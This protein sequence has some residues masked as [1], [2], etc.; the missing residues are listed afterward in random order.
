MVGSISQARHSVPC[1]S[2]RM[3]LGRLVLHASAHKI[4]TFLPLFKLSSSCLSLLVQGLQACSTSQGASVALPKHLSLVVGVTLA[5]C[6]KTGTNFFLCHHFMR[7]FVLTKNPD[8]LWQFLF[9]SLNLSI[10]PSHLKIALR[11][12]VRWFLR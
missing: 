11:G 3:P 9:S 4:N 1:C 8:G 2:E 7:R 12:L 10:L 6:G 5:V